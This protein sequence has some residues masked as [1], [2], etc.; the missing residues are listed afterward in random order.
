M[1][2]LRK[3]FITEINSKK[4]KNSKQIFQRVPLFS[5]CILFTWEIYILTFLLRNKHQ[6]IYIL[7]YIKSLACTED[8]REEAEELRGQIYPTHCGRRRN[9]KDLV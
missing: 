4:S 6:K 3:H 1:K 2:C 7:I 8:G 5:F 9:L